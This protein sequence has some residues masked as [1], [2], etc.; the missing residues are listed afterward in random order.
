MISIYQNQI[1]DLEI[2]KKFIFGGN[3][4]FTLV[5]KKTKKRFTFKLKK[6]KSKEAYWIS[7]LRGPDNTSDY[8]YIGA[9]FLDDGFKPKKETD[10]YSLKAIGWFLNNLKND[11]LSNQVE[12]WHEGRCGICGRRL[13][14]PESIDI[15]IGPECIKRI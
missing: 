3:S 6:A 2:A 7:R 12:L 11:H 14:V 4:L 10:A 15:G 5:S 9:F 8:E 1:K 13:T